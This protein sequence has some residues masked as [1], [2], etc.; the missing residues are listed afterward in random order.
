MLVHL[1]E[2]MEENLFEATGQT[3][4]ILLSLKFVFGIH[5]SLAAFVCPLALPPWVVIYPE[6]TVA[7]ES[8]QLAGV[9]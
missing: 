6:V 4:P 7:V 8:I 3:S 5:C 1:F 9:E 2:L